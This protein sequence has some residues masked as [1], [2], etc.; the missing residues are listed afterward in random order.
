MLQIK[1]IFVEM[2]VVKIRQIVQDV[3][4]NGKSIVYLRGIGRTLS[5]KKK[6]VSLFLFSERKNENK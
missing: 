3:S 6:I 1:E 4:S 5:L 2:N